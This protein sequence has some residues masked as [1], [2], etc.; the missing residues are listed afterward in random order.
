MPA[1]SY[2]VSAHG[3]AS[4]ANDTWPKSADSN[5]LALARQL[6]RTLC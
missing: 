4:T 6:L 5:R 1:G 2:A 3:S